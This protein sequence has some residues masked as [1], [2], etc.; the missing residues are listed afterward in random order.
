M[1]AEDRCGATVNRSS[2][3]LLGLERDPV[4]GGQSCVIT[5]RPKDG[6]IAF[7]DPVASVVIGW[8]WRTWPESV[9]EAQSAGV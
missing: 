3:T 5:P 8:A 7:F 2:G 6:D 4:T 9:K 1:Y